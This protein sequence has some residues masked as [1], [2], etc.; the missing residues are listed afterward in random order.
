VLHLGLASLAPPKAR[1]GLHL[2]AQTS[3]LLYR[4]F[5]IRRRFEVAAQC[6]LAAVAPKRRLARRLARREGG[7]SAPQQVGNLRYL[8]LT[9][10][11]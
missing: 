4:G 11:V 8:R 10:F 7:K 3:S 5:P 9:K 2:V 6:R 1:C